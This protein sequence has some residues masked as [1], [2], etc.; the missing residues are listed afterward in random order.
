MASL[1]HTSLGATIHGVTA[2]DEKVWQFRGIRYATIPGRFEVAEPY[3]PSEDVTW[4]PR[5]TSYG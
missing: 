2:A 4:S 1:Q 5:C 3:I